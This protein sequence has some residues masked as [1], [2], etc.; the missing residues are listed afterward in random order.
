MLVDWT[1]TPIKADLMGQQK[2]RQANPIAIIE[3]AGYMRAHGKEPSAPYAKLIQHYHGWV[4]H[5]AWI[6]AQA[7]SEVP[8]KLFVAG[9]SE[10]VATRNPAP[11]TKAFNGNLPHARRKAMPHGG[12]FAEVLEHPAFAVLD[13]PNPYMT[14][15]EMRQ[16]LELYRSLTGNAYLWKERGALNLVVGLW[17]LPSQYMRMVPGETEILD[18]YLYKKG[19]REA[20]FTPDE[21]I[22]FR[23]PNP[24]D[25]Y[26]YGYGETES[27]ANI[28]ALGDAIDDYERRTLENN[29]RPDFVLESEMPMDRQQTADLRREFWRLHGSTSNA[30]RF[31]ILSGGLE[32]KPIGWSPKDVSY[33]KGEDKIMRRIGMAMGIPKSMLTTDDVNLANAEIGERQHAKYTVKP[34]LEYDCEQLTERWLI[35]YDERLFWGFD[36]PTPENEKEQAEIDE[37]RLR[38]KLRTINEIR[39]RDN[40]EPL[41]GGDEISQP[42][43]AFPAGFMS[44][45][46][47]TAH[48]GHDGHY[49]SP[50]AL[51]GPQA[52]GNGRK[53]VS[54]MPEDS[55]EIRAFARIMRGLFAQQRQQV[56]GDNK[57][58]KAVVPVGEGELTAIEV[59]A[60]S[61]ALTAAAPGW[62]EATAAATGSTLAGII[63]AGAERGVTIL[64]ERGVEIA[65]DVTRAEVVRAIFAEDYTKRW[66]SAVTITTRDRVHAHIAAAYEHGESIPQLRDR[67]MNM[68]DGFDKKRATMIARTEMSRAVGVGQKEAWRQSGQVTETRWICAYDC[69]PFCAE[70]DGRTI[71]ISPGATYADLGTEITAADGSTYLVNYETFEGARGINGPPLHPNCRCE[72]SPILVQR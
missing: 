13:D 11:K 6:N 72:E 47:E 64:S 1:G 23:R 62:A 31:A 2:P 39:A 14:G 36:D 4:H 44:Y 63:A 52:G 33:L 69:C 9:G 32:L 48:I 56:L 66:A 8:L 34:R 20:A 54:E 59:E 12:E 26:F 17:P 68:F 24:N 46:T 71:S 15:R 16:L 45:T 67:L 29:A 60:M 18:G 65:F 21:I 28:A 7:V 27:E 51:P 22:H 55:P 49:H 50:K 70:L 19:V 10:K 43:P 38:S 40:L 53:Q 25:P 5:C 57:A 37:I 42:A 3:Q 30:Q 58:V 41:E 61:E 35:E